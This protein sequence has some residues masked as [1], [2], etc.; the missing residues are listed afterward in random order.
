LHNAHQHKNGENL[1]KCERADT[2]NGLM[3]SSSA[4]LNWEPYMSQNVSHEAGNELVFVADLS[5]TPPN[6]TVTCF[7]RQRDNN[8]MD[9]LDSTREFI[10]T[11]AEITHNRY[12]TQFRV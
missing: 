7:T 8:N 2:P 1:A 12:N 6:H 4:V 5:D 9:S 11:I 3:T 10:A